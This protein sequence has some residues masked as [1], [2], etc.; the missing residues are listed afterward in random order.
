MESYGA[1]T[2]REVE[3]LGPVTIPS[4]ASNNKLFMFYVL[5]MVSPPGLGKAQL[6]KTVK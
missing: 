6:V 1:A 2:R 3:L 4:D 5:F